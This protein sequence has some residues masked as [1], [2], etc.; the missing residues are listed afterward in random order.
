[1]ASSRL[2]TQQSLH[3]YILIMQLNDYNI[4]YRRDENEM[5]PI[6]YFGVASVP[7]STLADGV[8]VMPLSR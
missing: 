7:W 2:Y 4:L 5:L 6:G 8:V 1:H 3:P